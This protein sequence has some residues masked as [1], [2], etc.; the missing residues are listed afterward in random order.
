MGA[1]VIVLLDT[2]RKQFLLAA[3]ELKGHV[4]GQLITPLTGFSDYGFPQYAIDNGAY[5]KWDERRFLGILDRQKPERSRCLFVSVPDVVGSARRTREVFD[6]WRD[7]LAGWP[8]AYV[9]Q[10]GSGDIDVPW[11]WIRAVFIG[12]TDKFKTSPEAVAVIK[13]AQLL[14][15]WVHVGRVNTSGRFDDC[16]K[17]GVDSVDGSGISRYSHMRERMVHPVLPEVQC[18][19]LLA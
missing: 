14:G 15:K 3:E 4:L 13:A 6:H 10:D 12:G 8:L 19:A 1:P 5:S 18:Q 2:T 17:L 11:E 9:A 7:R 16:L